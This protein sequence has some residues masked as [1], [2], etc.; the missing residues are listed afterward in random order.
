MQNEITILGLLSYESPKYW[1]L[2]HRSI[3]N[4]I[5]HNCKIR[6]IIGLDRVSK[7]T[8]KELKSYLPNL[9]TF[10]TS[11]KPSIVKNGKENKTAK[12]IR[13]G[14]LYNNLYSKIPN[15]SKYCFMLDGDIAFVKKDWDILLTSHLKD[16][17]VVIGHEYSDRWPGKYQNFPCVQCSLFDYQAI[18]NIRIDFRGTEK[19]LVIKEPE[20]SEVFGIKNGERLNRDIGWEWPLMI[21]NAGFTGKVMK[22][23]QGENRQA[24]LL[25]PKS[26]NDK[27]IYKI[28]QKTGIKS[29][30][31]FHLD[32]M[33][34]G[35]HL[36]KST[37]L[38]YNEHPISQFWIKRVEETF[39]L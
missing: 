12:R 26:E 36:T 29:L 39:S 15:D 33:L 5:S 28:N 19:D 17:C 3:E 14:S 16:K 25:M 34:I 9:I 11:I 10:D 20:Q 35:T 22:F 23:I 18:K 2:C 21:K 32:D 13:I 37:C 6:Y 8:E 31:E 4:T 27:K 1:H 38:K 24:K 7:E 30:F